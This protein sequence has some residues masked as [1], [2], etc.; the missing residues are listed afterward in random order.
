VFLATDGAMKQRRKSANLQERL[1]GGHHPVRD[2]AGVSVN[3]KE[4]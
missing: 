2:F 1:S 3:S 4:E